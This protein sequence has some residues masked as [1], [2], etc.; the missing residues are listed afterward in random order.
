MEADF[1]WTDDQLFSF[2]EARGRQ[3]SASSETPDYIFKNIIDEIGLT[4]E[5]T[6]AQARKQWD[7]LVNK[8]KELSQPSL[9]P[10]DAGPPGWQFYEP[11][12][13]AFL[14]MPPSVLPIQVTAHPDDDD[15]EETVVLLQAADGESFEEEDFVEDEEEEFEEMDDEDM[16]PE[17]EEEDEDEEDY[18]GAGETMMEDLADEEMEDEDSQD[19]SEPLHGDVEDQLADDSNAEDIWTEPRTRAFIELRCA[20][21]TDMVNMGPTPVFSQIINELGLEGSVTASAAR[22][23]WTQLVRRYLE[24]KGPDGEEDKPKIENG[25]VENDGWPFFEQM[26]Q[27]MEIIKATSPDGYT[28]T[29]KSPEYTWSLDVTRKFIRLRGEKHA[30]IS[31]KGHNQVYKEILEKIGIADKITVMMAR[32]KWNYLLKRYQYEGTCSS[33]KGLEIH[34]SI[35][36]LFMY[37]KG[38]FNK[39]AISKHIS[40]LWCWPNDLTRR[41]IEMRI[42]RHQDFHETGIQN[43]YTEI[44]EELGLEHILNPN[45][46]RKKWNYLVAKYKELSCTTGADGN[47]PAP[48]SWP[49]YDDM[50]EALQQIPESALHANR[51]PRTNFDN[52]WTKDITI[53]FI[54]L[55]GAKQ[56]DTSKK[57]AQVFGDILEEL[58]LS[59]VINANQARKKWN[60]LWSKYVDL[61]NSEVNDYTRQSWPFY[62]TMQ[63]VVGTL[64]ISHVLNKKGIA[65]EME[66]L[67]DDSQKKIIKRMRQYTCFVCGKTGK[68]LNDFFMFEQDQRL[69]YTQKTVL[70]VISHLVGRKM[71]NMEASTCLCAGCTN[72]V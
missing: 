70:E 48:H 18:D 14:S 26:D 40:D 27:V 42:A 9:E 41:F 47:S 2:I 39:T 38:Q 12:Q 37:L 68:I 58:G 17:E 10:E 7:F 63:A 34:V 15:Q 57:V 50:H 8:Y 72:L 22:K 30:E 29:R 61:S 16:M 1:M 5:V 32:K 54:Q 62:E 24:M 60:Y 11:M 19:V 35:A 23:K 3:K 28:K 56:P 51:Q 36:S 64:P 55:R 65:D 53:R 52:I 69:L 13:D 59:G 33:Y 46:L 43:T 31:K 6:V 67:E 21:E 45:Q 49:F 44:M 4:G 20:K 66:D 25:E 71:S